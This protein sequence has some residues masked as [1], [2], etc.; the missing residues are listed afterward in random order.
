MA[1]IFA[2]LHTAH[3]T[4]AEELFDDVRRENSLAAETILLALFSSERAA[5]KAGLSLL[6]RLQWNDRKAAARLMVGMI[7]SQPLENTSPPPSL[8]GV[9]KSSKHSVLSA[10]FSFYE[11]SRQSCFTSSVSGSSDIHE[12]GRA[13][14][15]VGQ[16]L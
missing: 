7:L 11:V 1:Q 10:H 9:I 14:R 13:W 12:L 6:E 16:A 5:R 8:L 15:P 2:D 3:R 4:A